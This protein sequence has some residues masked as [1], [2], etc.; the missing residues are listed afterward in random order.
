MAIRITNVRIPI[1]EPEAELPGRLARVLGLPSAQMTGWRILR[2]SL[3][4]RDKRELQF[5]YNAEVLVPDEP[6]VVA[7]AAPGRPERVELFHEPPFEIPT[8]GTLP[9]RHRPVVIGSGPGG[10]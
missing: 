2:K 5:V 4:V 9:L 7:K 3:D 10:L 6:G 1:D 8:P